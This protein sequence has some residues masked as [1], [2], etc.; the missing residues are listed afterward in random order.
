MKATETKKTQIYI[1]VDGKEYTLAEARKLVKRYIQLK[2]KI[3]ELESEVSDIGKELIAFD[4][5]EKVQIGENFVSVSNCTKTAI[6]YTELAKKH[7]K[8]AKEFANISTY[9]RINV[10]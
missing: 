3:K 4:G 8:I 5:T 2:A 1:G 7:P 9:N 6:S 10:K